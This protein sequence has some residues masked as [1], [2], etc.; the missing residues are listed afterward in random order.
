MKTRQ[1]FFG[2]CASVLLS[3]V[4]AQAD[5]WEFDRDGN[6]FVSPDVPP[7]DRNNRYYD[8]NVSGEGAATPVSVS[9]RNADSAVYRP[10]A[11]GVAEVY[12]AIRR[13]PAP[14]STRRISSGSSSR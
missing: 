14:G 12:A 5:V 6:I 2:L 3:G 13:S 11:E 10:M 4:V 1:L 8:R 9:T 7:A